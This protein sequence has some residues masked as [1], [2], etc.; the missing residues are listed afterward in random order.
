M[1]PALSLDVAEW[2]ALLR[3][4]TVERLGAAAAA[5][6]IP[7]RYR[8]RLPG[9]A[10]DALSC[11]LPLLQDD[12]AA[13]VVFC[14]PHGD[15]ASAGAL[16]SD[17]ARREL[18]SPTVFSLSVHNAPAGVLSLCV[19]GPGDHTAIAG[20]AGT[21]PAGMIEARARLVLD[22][23][24]SV[25]LVYADE[26]PSGLYADFAEEEAPGVFA[27]LKLRLGSGSAAPTAVVAPTRDGA[28]ALVKALEAGARRLRFG[29]P[30]VRTAA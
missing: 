1:T 22:E 17:I 16:L 6:L 14:S 9:F 3:G 11:A 27:A 26:R 24:K 29:L 4:Q 25:V 21:L 5:D 20:G 2:A 13:P 30:T 12:P 19:S 18:L 15:L 28:L 10:R 7:E 23:A 8:R